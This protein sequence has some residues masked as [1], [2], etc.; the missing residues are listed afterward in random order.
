[1]LIFI[2][3]IETTLFVY[4]YPCLIEYSLMSVTVFYIMWRNVDRREKPTHVD[5][6][7]RHVY[8]LNCSRASRGLLSGGIILLLTIITLIP[9]YVLSPASAIPI[10]H[11]TELVLLFIAFVTVCLAFVFT[12][13][14]H[15]DRDAHVNF[16]D[17]IL[18]LVTTVGDFAYSLFG[19]FAAIFIESYSINIPR[20]VEVAINVLA[21]LQTFVQSAFILDCLKRRLITSKDVRE[22]PGRELITALLLIN[23]SKR[24]T[25][26]LR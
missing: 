6:N 11:V 10:T 20:T 14:L 22:K 13:K 17:Q 3:K 8:K 23:L 1:M 9:D 12:T 25:Q 16:F 2:E 21:I 26:V 24:D 15:Y 18:I 4:L 5:F 19:L 7:H